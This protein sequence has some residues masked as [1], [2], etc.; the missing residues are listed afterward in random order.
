VLA[1]V[2]GQDRKGRKLE[3]LSEMM[4]G[5]G[6]GGGPKE[7]VKPSWG[8][9][10]AQQKEKE[11][12][13]SR[14]RADGSGPVARY[15]IDE[16]TDK[17]KRD[18]MRFDDPMAQ[19]L[20]KKAN[21]SNKPKYRGPPP[22]ANRFNLPPGFRWDGVDRSNGYEKQYFMAQAKARREASEAHAWATAD[23]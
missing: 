12:K 18:E 10:L 21:T 13:R 6:E 3:M 9:G 15:T 14:A 22:P 19:H 1:R 8:S 7:P 2:R 5:Q 23:M 16:E 11:Q 17:E 4:K 20:S